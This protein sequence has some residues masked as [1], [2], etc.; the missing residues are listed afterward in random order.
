MSEGCTRW[1][2]GGWRPA[3][4][5]GGLPSGL[6][7]WRA[8]E[9]DTG[10][11][12]ELDCQGSHYALL[13][14]GDCRDDLGRSANM[15]YE[16]DKHT[17]L[18]CKS[19]CDIDPQCIAY[20]YV[21]PSVDLEPGHGS[22]FASAPSRQAGEHPGGTGWLYR[23]GDG[24]SEVTTTLF[25]GGDEHGTG[26]CFLKVDWQERVLTRPGRAAPVTPRKQR[27]L[28]VGPSRTASGSSRSLSPA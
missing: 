24:A 11:T 2:R 9:M 4:A 12:W 14:T 3:P 18:T 17:A 10:G 27:P 26:W 28:A 8:G 20:H 1:Q 7:E 13:G 5:V 16:L 19:Q 6:S 22:C 23:A 15:Y 21:P 25:A